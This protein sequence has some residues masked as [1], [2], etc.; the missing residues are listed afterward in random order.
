MKI[1]NPVDLAKWVCFGAGVLLAGAAGFE[2]LGFN[3]VRSAGPEAL[4]IVSIPFIL[5]GK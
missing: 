5:L 4:G 2:L 3:V 1:D